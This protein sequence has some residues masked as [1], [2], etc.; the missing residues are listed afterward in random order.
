MSDSISLGSLVSPTLRIQA[1]SRLLSHYHVSGVISKMEHIHC[2]LE[3]L[4]SGSRC[5]ESRRGISETIDET[6]LKRASE[7]S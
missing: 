7:P 1:Y 3:D 2:E 4:W 5:F 6:A